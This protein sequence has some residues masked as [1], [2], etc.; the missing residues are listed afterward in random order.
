MMENE[1]EIVRI[2]KE[3]LVR[4]KEIEKRGKVYKI[5]NGNER[6][7]LKKTNITGF[8]R[9]F[10]NLQFLYRR[11]FYRYVPI[12]PAK[13]GNY[14]VYANGDLYYLMPWFADQ[15]TEEKMNGM[16]RELGRLHTI[17]AKDWKI[18]KE[19][20]DNH[21][22]RA[23]E[24]WEAEAAFLERF[25][26]QCENK[27]YMSPFEWT[28]VQYFH[29]F[30][31]A[32]DYALRQLER[33]RNEMVQVGKIRSVLTHGKFSGDHF[34][35][36]SRGYGYFI[37]MEK[38]RHASPLYDLLPFL[39]TSLGSYPKPCDDCLTWLTVYM[40]FFP[41]REGEKLLMKSYLAQPG[42]ILHTLGTYRSKEIKREY[43]FTK[44]MQK[45]YWLLKNTEYVVMK[46]EEMEGATK[47]T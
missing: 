16:F 23:R 42:Y 46:L 9:M 20:V 44:Q 6:F 10:Q 24:K 47:D 32:Y 34:L 7:A 17:S 27:W 36:N 40:K 33:W 45:H 18:G 11:G 28:F 14:A 3:Y 41:L 37:S 21:Y 22:G 2:L 19:T 5:D 4:P 8:Q 39:L 12:L 38:S 26:E 43:S 15:R 30:R 13:N 35:F 29:E 1:R 31:K 25:L